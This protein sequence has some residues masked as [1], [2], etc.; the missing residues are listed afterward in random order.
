MDWQ[1][2]LNKRII[3]N[4]KEDYNKIKSIIEIS[5]EKRKTAE[6]L[7]DEHYYGKFSLLYD[8]LRELLECL[9]LKE[10]YKI[11]NHEC[12][13]SFL[14]EIVKESKL[15]DSFDKLRVIRN[16]INYEGKQITKEEAKIIIIQTIEAINKV[17]TITRK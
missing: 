9:A 6:S 15:G 3:K 14:K 7:S 13:T 16:R 17:K 2:C 4:V 5:E 1:E 8:A 12:Y 11:Y 10:G